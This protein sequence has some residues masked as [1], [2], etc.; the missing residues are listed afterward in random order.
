VVALGRHVDLLAHPGDPRRVHHPGDRRPVVPQPP[1]GPVDV[2]W[3][4]GGGT[5]V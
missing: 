1:D 2:P 3:G 4:P 5:G